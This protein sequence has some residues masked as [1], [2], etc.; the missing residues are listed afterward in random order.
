MKLYNLLI[1]RKLIIIPSLCR[2]LTPTLAH[3][4]RVC[5]DFAHWMSCVEIASFLAMTRWLLCMR[6]CWNNPD[7]YQGSMTTTLMVALTRQTDSFGRNQVK[8]WWP[9]AAAG[10]LGVLPEALAHARQPAATSPLPRFYLICG[11]KALCGKRSI[12]YDLIFDYFVSRQSN[13]PSGE[14][15][16][17][18]DK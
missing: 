9:C 17:P 10:V 7:S 6:R 5:Q 3:A 1:I 18:S 13:S 16:T 15:A 14:W 2:K 12:P 4:C 11:V 8:Q